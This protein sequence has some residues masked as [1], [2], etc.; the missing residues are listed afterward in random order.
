MTKIGVF[1]A[2]A[3]HRKGVGGGSVSASFKRIF[4]RSYEIFLLSLEGR[5]GV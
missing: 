3:T 1:L 4:E 5:S 2:V